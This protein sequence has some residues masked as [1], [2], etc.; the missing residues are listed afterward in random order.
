MVN[1]SSAALAQELAA[2]PTPDEGKRLA[3][4]AADFIDTYDVAGLSVAIAI[5]GKPAYV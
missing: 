5:K 3:R 2:I 4:L 1:G